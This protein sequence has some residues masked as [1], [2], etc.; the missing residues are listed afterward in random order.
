[1]SEQEAAQEGTKLLAKTLQTF[2]LAPNGIQVERQC[3]R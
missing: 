3:A 1:M 2:G